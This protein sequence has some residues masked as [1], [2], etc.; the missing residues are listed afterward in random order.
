MCGGVSGEGGT[1]GQLLRFCAGVLLDTLTV[2]EPDYDGDAKHS[3]Y[4]CKSV[5]TGLQF[6]I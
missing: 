2:S 1:F 3:N 6:F 4:E 5:E